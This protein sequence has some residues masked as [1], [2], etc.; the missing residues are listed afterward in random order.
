MARATY[1][2][3]AGFKRAVG[4]SV[5][6]QNLVSIARAKLRWKARLDAAQVQPAA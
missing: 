5:I 6:C 3:D 2:G 4:W 1:K